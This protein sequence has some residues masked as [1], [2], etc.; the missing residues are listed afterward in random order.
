[1]RY[2]GL[3]RRAVWSIIT[4][5]KNA[6]EN[7]MTSDII[8]REMTARDWDDVKRIYEQA[9]PDASATFQTQCAPYPEW[10]EKHC[11]T[12][13]FVAERDGNVIGWCAL[14]PT[15]PMPIYSG[16]VEVS[17]YIDRDF[18]GL[19][20]GTSL[21]SRVCEESEK[22]GYWCIYSSI[23]PE[24]YGSI[25]IHEKCGFRKI[26]YREK[27]AKDRFGVWRDTVLYERRSKIVF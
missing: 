11:D 4:D 24:N 14:S 22:N 10:D 19:G 7:K 16:V 5:I 13:R 20:I 2:S 1:M 17:I 25:R 26:G 18:S 27:I 3:N 9:L 21:L 15:S 6:L 12:C 23:F 8:I